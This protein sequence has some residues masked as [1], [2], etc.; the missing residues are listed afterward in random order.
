[1]KINTNSWHYRLNHRMNPR[2][3][4]NKLCGYFWHTVT[5]IIA[6]IMAIAG[7]LVIFVLLIL[8][9]VNAPL[10]FCSSVLLISGSI[11]TAQAIHR[12][13]PRENLLFTWMKA[14]KRKVC[15]Y[16]EFIDSNEESNK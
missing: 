5:N 16:I 8:L 10:V 13:Q 12:S 14:K 6:V 3:M 1:M 4:P 9:L 15:P 11:R 2:Y 7:T